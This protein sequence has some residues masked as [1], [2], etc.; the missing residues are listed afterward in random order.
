LG[1]S[2][3]SSLLS[4]E[5]RALPQLGQLLAHLIDCRQLGGSPLYVVLHHPVGLA[6]ITISTDEDRKNVHVVRL[7]MFLR[8]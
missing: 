6:T 3:G 8:N 5:P 4:S 2:I 1:K 7:I